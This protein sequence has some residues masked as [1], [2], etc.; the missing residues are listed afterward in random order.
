MSF[1]CEQVF[2]GL[3]DR[4][5]PLPDWCEVGSAGGFVFAAWSCDCRSEGGGVLLEVAA[6][7]ALVCDDDD[8]AVVLE[9]AQ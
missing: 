3:E 5:D 1:E 2:A 9:P 8:R 7:V 4:L 6:G